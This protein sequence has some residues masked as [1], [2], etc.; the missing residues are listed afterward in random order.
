MS[1]GPFLYDEG[2]EQ[3]HT[4][5]PR[6]RRGFL[7]WVFGGTAL[8]AVLMVVVL[9]LVT[10][11]AGDQSRE[12]VQVFLAALDKG[13]NDTAYQLLCEKERA[14]LTPDDVAARYLGGDGAG[15]IVA[16]SDTQADGDPVQRVRVEWPDGSH[17]GFTVVNSDGPHVCGVTPEG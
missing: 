17:T 6:R 10:G 5:V 14:A 1:N 12:V 7:L 3:L 4:D 2:P 9:P 11:S 8:V 13:D 16:V 15:Q